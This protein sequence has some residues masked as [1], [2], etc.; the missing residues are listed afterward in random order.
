VNIDED[1]ASAIEFIES[2]KLPWATVLSSEGETGGNWTHPNVKR[3]GISEIPFVAL[4][5]REGNVIDIHVRGEKLGQ[6]LAELFPEEGASAAGAEETGA[7]PR[8]TWFVAFETPTSD[9]VSSEEDVASDEAEEAP[10]DEVSDEVSD[11]SE[12]TPSGVEANPYS[13]PASFTPEQLAEFLLNMQ[14]KPKSI[15]SRPGFN[16]A[17]VEASERLLADGAPAKYRNM[18]VLTKLDTLHKQASLGNESADQ[19]LDAYLAEVA[20]E[21]AAEPSAK[22][23]RDVQFFQLERRVLEAKDLPLDQLPALFAEL[24]DYF[25]KQKLVA[26][27]LRIASAT[28]DAINR[29]EDGADR[30]KLYDEFGKLFAASHDKDLELYGKKLVKTPEGA[31]SDVVGKPLELAGTTT[32]GT[33]FDWNAYKGKVVLVDFWATWCG[34]CR[35]AM[36]TVKA[37]YER[38]KEFGLDIVGVSLD[39]DQDALAAYLEENQIA[40][41][42]LAGEKTQELATKYGVRGIPTLMLVGKDGLVV[43]VSHSVEDLAE[44]AR[45]LVGAPP[46]TE[47]LPKAESPASPAPQAEPPA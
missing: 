18:A 10:S 15:Q 42:T 6:R 37:V 29:L 3:C 20:A 36:P 44:K 23:A 31:E 7:I 41:S 45:E 9:E 28:I 17:I 8:Q 30:E 47:P 13:A 11:E 12:A 4:L 5:D 27:H 24:K 34:P 46:S 43:A 33:E 16:E 14:Y 22:I 38:Y 39:Q 32:H 21:L 40:W 35:K 26:R 1:R 2:E 19:A 25:A